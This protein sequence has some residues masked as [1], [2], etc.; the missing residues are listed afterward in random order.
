MTPTVP[1]E[2]KDNGLY[3]IADTARM[4]QVCRKTVYNM[5]NGQHL[6]VKYRK[7]DMNRYVTGVSIKRVIENVYF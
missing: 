7:Y 1:Q 4:L 2:L 3:S 6:D 5:I